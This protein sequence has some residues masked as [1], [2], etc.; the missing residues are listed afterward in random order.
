MPLEDG[1]IIDTDLV[2]N[3]R[4]KYVAF[5]DL[6]GFRALVKRSAADLLERHRL[7]EALKLVRDT[8]C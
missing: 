7:V 6:L 8:L 4:R 3:Y 1:E 5:L 2:N